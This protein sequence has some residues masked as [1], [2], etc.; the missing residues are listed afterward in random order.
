MDRGIIESLNDERT[1]KQRCTAQEKQTLKAELKRLT[2]VK[3][4][5]ERDWKPANKATASG[6]LGVEQISDNMCGLIVMYCFYLG[7]VQFQ[8]IFPE[9]AS[10]LLWR[11]G[12][13]PFYMTWHVVQCMAWMLNVEADLVDDFEDTDLMEKYHGNMDSYESACMA[14]IKKILANAVNG[15]DVGGKKRMIVHS[16]GTMTNFVEQFGASVNKK[17]FLVDHMDVLPFSFGMNI[18]DFGVCFN[19]NDCSEY[20]QEYIQNR[21]VVF[22]PVI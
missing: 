1:L 3:K 4:K 8:G 14:N 12:D 6:E 16:C 9:I 15:G 10:Y 17:K 5:V 19:P 22:V 20:K 18:R 11:E 2:K 7:Q 21:F 13:V